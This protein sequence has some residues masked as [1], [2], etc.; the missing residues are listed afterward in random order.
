M[1]IRVSS[2]QIRDLDSDDI[3][4]LLSLNN[5]NW[6][7]TSL[8]DEGG[9]SALL[10]SAYYA[11]G[12]DGGARAFLIA[13]DQHA[14]YANPNFEWFKSRF[15]SFIYVDRVIVGEANR[16]RGLGKELYLD[17]FTFAR[18]AG[19]H[20]I[21]CEVNIAP[22]NLASEE[23]HAN[24]GFTSVGEASIYDGKKTVRYFEK[25]LE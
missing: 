6:E 14:P 10:K 17:L 15:E 5:A 3:P 9:M 21:V 1:S 16:G 11:R 4:A 23:F 18:E 19:D 20:R 2:T 24:M 7:E 8:L 25:L 22:P 12:L 13:F